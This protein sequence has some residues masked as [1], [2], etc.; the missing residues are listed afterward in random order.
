MLFI[1]LAEVRLTFPAEDVIAFPAAFVVDESW[2]SWAEAE[3]R[4][5]EL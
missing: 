4:A 1:E 3:L 2:L 5:P